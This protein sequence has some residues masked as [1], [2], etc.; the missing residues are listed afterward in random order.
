MVI[1]VQ[2]LDNVYVFLE[3]VIFILICFKF[4]VSKD[5]YYHSSLY[6]ITHP[7]L[8]YNYY[9]KT[10]LNMMKASMLFF[11]SF[12]L[13]KYVSDKLN[14]HNIYKNRILQHIIIN[15]CYY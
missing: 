5:H 11:N 10:K 4:N 7:N 3:Y 12:K 8:N 2:V 6:L 9:N 1:K 15:K 14:V 13:N